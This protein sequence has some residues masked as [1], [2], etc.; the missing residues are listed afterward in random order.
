LLDIFERV[1]PDPH[2]GYISR[3]RAERHPD[4]HEGNRGPD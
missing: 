3:Q 4:A 2:R 1:N